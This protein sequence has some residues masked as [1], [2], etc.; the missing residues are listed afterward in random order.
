MC[1]RSI[2]VRE[3]YTNRMVDENVRLVLLADCADTDAAGACVPEG[4]FPSVL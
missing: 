2:H 1:A 3:R 4:V